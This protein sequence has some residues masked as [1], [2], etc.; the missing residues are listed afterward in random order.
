MEECAGWPLTSGA[1]GA[2]GRGY[3][4]KL[5][6]CPRYGGTVI[7]LLPRLVMAGRRAEG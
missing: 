3:R 1:G 7:L 6:D 2:G 5:C 4:R